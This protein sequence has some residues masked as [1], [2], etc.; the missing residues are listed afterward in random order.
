M[1]TLCYVRYIS[2]YNFVELCSLVPNKWPFIY[3]WL[4]IVQL[5]II[6]DFRLARRLCA[7]FAP[8]SS[9][10]ILIVFLHTI[11][12]VVC[13]PFVHTFIST[14]FQSSPNIHSSHHCLYFV[15]GYELAVSLPTQLQAQATY[16]L[17]NIFSVATLSLLFQ[18][19]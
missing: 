15:L 3:T 13:K 14:G 4:G 9:S 7:L 16:L 2:A 8:L 18:R 5:S 12:M 17:W 11:L 1:L 6:C 10:T 19:S